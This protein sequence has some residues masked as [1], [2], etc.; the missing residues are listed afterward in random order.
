MRKINGF[1]GVD[2]ISYSWDDIE[3]WYLNTVNQVGSNGY[4][5]PKMRLDEILLKNLTPEQYRFIEFLNSEF[6]TIITLKPDMQSKLINRLERLGCNQLLFDYNTNETTQFGKMVL[7]AFRYKEF[8]DNKLV[9]LAE[10]QNIKTCLYCNSQY[11]LTI[12]QKNEKLAM[13][14]FDHFFPKSKYPYLSISLFNLIP[15][16]PSCNLNKSAAFYKLDRF[17]HPFVEDFHK[18]FEFKIPNRGHIKLLQGEMA[19]KEELKPF[20]YPSNSTKVKNYIKEFRLTGIYH[21]HT[22]IVEEIYMTAYAYKNKGKEALLDLVNEN[23]RKIFNSKEEIER[24]LL[25]NFT[26][27]ED[28]NKRPLSKFMQDM[29]KQSGLIER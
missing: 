27:E 15:A 16:C 20:L 26:L 9:L 25:K 10:K 8:R 21:R 22:D 17:V 3:T 29:A 4:K 1:I 24:L 6:D 2:G 13:F 18:L 14:Q 11:T 5:T 28:I 12:E 7:W 23:G 19:L